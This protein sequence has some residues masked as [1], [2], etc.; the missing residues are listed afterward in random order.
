MFQVRMRKN[1]DSEI[2][3]HTMAEFIS[4]VI[5]FSVALFE[6]VPIYY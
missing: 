3:A 1:H 6:P 2:R 5:L 4:A